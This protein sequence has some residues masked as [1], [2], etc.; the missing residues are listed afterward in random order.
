[1]D[2][3]R[4]SRTADIEDIDF[5]TNTV[6]LK[7]SYPA[8]TILEAAYNEVSSED[9]F[10]R[11][12]STLQ[13]AKNQLLPVGLQVEIKGRITAGDGGAATYLVAPNQVVDGY[14]DHLAANNNALLLQNSDH[15][16]LLQYGS[17]PGTLS[18]GA[19]LAAFEA[20][21]I[22]K[23]PIYI[24]VSDLEH[25]VD[26]QL[27]YYGYGLRGGSRLGSVL[28]SSYVGTMLKKMNSN[29][30][31][32]LLDFTFKG[33][34]SGV[35]GTIGF[36]PDGGTKGFFRTQANN[37]HF[38]EMEQALEVQF[39][40]FC[41]FDTFYVRDVKRGVFFVGG[42]SGWNNT[43]Y[44]N[45]ISFQN[46]IF[47]EC[48]EYAID[49]V[50]VGLAFDGS[51]TIQSC[52]DGLVIDRDTSTSTRTNT[53]DNLYF[54]F[55]TGHDLKL[56][57]T[58]ITL[59]PV[60]F[61]SGP[62]N[63]PL[64]NILCDD[65]TIYAVGRPNYLD[66]PDVRVSL[67]NNSKLVA[68]YPEIVSNK[69]ISDATSE[70]VYLPDRTANK[71]ITQIFNDLDTSP[72]TLAAPIDTSTRYTNHIID[73]MIEAPNGEYT[74]FKTYGKL[75]AGTFRTN[76]EGDATYVS[77]NEFTVTIG[78]FVYT[79]LTVSGSG[80]ITIEADSTAT[81]DTLLTTRVVDSRSAQVY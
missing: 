41:N 80:A 67:I 14:G 1:V 7:N 2:R 44:N 5:G 25:M 70:Y 48:S 23:L 47:D 11:S 12:Y 24:N 21:N 42:G 40:L 15:I 38:R 58:H 30:E 26:V 64:F 56:K 69:I 71:A 17:V 55:N 35:A 43:W 16:S 54:E 52:G 37:V 57:F 29:D 53:V 20:Q 18:N 75:R 49:F 74:S 59:G 73:F 13:E 19:I 62:T 77:D 78:G 39:S 45:G 72:V 50:G 46:C 8:G 9:L 65:S 51:N 27:P 4:L 6:T 33:S 10:V 76:V 68:L 66:L 60:M 63:T 81:G 22:I 32:Q 34:G 79:F 61:Q 31:G 36:G 3:G 28:Q